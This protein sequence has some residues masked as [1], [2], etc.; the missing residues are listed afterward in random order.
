MNR[1]WAIVQILKEDHAHPERKPRTKAEIME[2]VGCGETLVK[3]MRR[4]FREDPNL[5]EE[6]L[7]EKKR[8]AKP[9]PFRKISAQMTL[10]LLDAIHKYSPSDYGLPYAGWCG[11]AVLALLHLGECFVSIKYMYKFLRRFNLN[12]K[13]AKRSNP[14][15]DPQEVALFK[16]ELYHEICRQA[17]ENNETIIFLDETGIQVDPGLKVYSIKGLEGHVQY[18]QSSRHTSGSLVSFI[19]P[20]GFIETFEV[21]GT[22]DA[23]QFREILKQLKKAY[24]DQKFVIILDNCRVHHAR[25]IQKWLKHWKGGRKFI[26]FVFLPPYAPEIN[27]VERLNQLLKA[28]LRKYEFTCSKDVLA[29]FREIVADFVKE[30]KEDPSKV[31][32]L[33][34]DSHC[35]YSIDEFRKV[36]AYFAEKLKAA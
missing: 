19:G 21:Q 17:L 8:G 12:S 36:E 6:D 2:I 4:L 24:P 14:K 5:K 27:P 32:K 11:V 23:L 29:K 31:T 18:T 9:K 25:I 3:K 13:V 7:L 15:Q 16:E 35:R 22:L 1:R 26:R 20:T 33:F 10:I 28:L 34:E 30:A